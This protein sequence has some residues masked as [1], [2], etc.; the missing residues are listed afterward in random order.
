MFQLLTANRSQRMMDGDALHC[1]PHLDVLGLQPH[2]TESARMMTLGLSSVLDQLT[3]N[4]GAEEMFGVISKIHSLGDMTPAVLMTLWIRAIRE[5]GKGSKLAQIIN[6]VDHYIRLTHEQRKERKVDEF[7]SQLQRLAPRSRSLIN[8]FQAWKGSIPT[9]AIVRHPE[10]GQALVI[11]QSGAEGTPRLSP[12]S[13]WGVMAEPVEVASSAV[14][15]SYFCTIHALQLLNERKAD[16]E[17][18]RRHRSHCPS[19]LVR[20]G[21]GDF[22]RQAGQTF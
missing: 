22:R 21:G 2:L 19:R 18:R 16:N 12:F 3:A 15:T 13:E 14:D 20:S 7:W 17:N 5:N 6:L 10:L 8:Q 11:D 1:R 9:G 4:Q